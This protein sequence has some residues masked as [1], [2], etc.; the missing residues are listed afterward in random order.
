MASRILDAIQ[1]F[2]GLIRRIRVDDQDVVRVAAAKEALIAE[3]LTYSLS[4]GNVLGEDQHDGVNGSNPCLSRIHLNGLL[5]HFEQRDA[6]TQLRLDVLPVVLPADDHGCLYELV[7]DGAI[8][9]VLI[10]DLFGGVLECGVA[11]SPSNAYG[12]RSRTESENF[13]P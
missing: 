12:V 13:L 7:R 8:K 4:V 3:D 11:V 10:D 9:R 5:L 6:I 2:E 1:L